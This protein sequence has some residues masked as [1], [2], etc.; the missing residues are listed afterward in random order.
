ME[1]NKYIWPEERVRAELRKMDKITGLKGA[2][3]PI[4]FNEAARTLGSFT[5]GRR[6]S[7]SFQFS[8]HYLENPNIPDEVNCDTI[9]HEYAHY[10]DWVIYGGSGH[11]KTW[12]ACCSKI[13]ALPLR[14]YNSGMAKHYRKIHEISEANLRRCSGYAVGQTVR[15][16]QFGTGVIETI[17]EAKEDRM[18]EVVFPGGTKKIFSACWMHDHCPGDGIV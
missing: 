2:E 13:D 10:M 16:P 3:L 1:E 4:R 17:R 11:G 12:K 9:R 6:E 5:P 8:R 14:L 7:G 18:L 15:H